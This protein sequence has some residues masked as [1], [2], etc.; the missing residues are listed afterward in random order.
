MGQVSAV[1]LI[2]YGIFRLLAE[3]TRLPDI[4]VGY[5]F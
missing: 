5:L 1:F 4:Q 2:G 3:L